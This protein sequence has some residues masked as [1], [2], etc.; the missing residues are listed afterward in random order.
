MATLQRNPKTARPLPPP[1]VWPADVRLMNAGTRALV[2][3]AVAVLAWAA[4]RWAMARPMFEV[5]QIQVVNAVQRVNPGAIESALMATGAPLPAARNFFSADLEAVSQALEAVPWVRR[6]QVFRLWPNTLRVRLEE[7]QPVALWEGVDGSE[8]KL[9][10]HHGEVFQANAAELEDDELP[11]LAGSEDQAGLLHAVWRQ[12]QPVLQAHRVNGEEQQVH[13]LSLSG[14]GAW[15]L[16]LDGGPVLE[17][18]RGAEAEVLAR[19][20]RF[21]G[22]LPSLAQRFAQPLEQADLR[23]QG[24]YAVRLQGVATGVVEVDKQK[25]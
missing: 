3:L 18:G 19:L 11:T 8:P 24:G 4:V 23:H 10:N 12:L 22:S 1:V 17:L 6:A 14:R 13:R 5:R 25:R 9:V 21:L 2:V 15:R 20:E 16:E 7:H